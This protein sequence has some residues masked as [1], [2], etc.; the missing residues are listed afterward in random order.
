MEVKLLSVPP[1]LTEALYR[2]PKSLPGVRHPLESFLIVRPSPPYPYL[3][4]ALKK[5]VPVDLK[6]LDDAWMGL[7]LT[8]RLQ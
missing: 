5:R 4:I 2:E 1:S 3:N 6:G 7:G 8:V